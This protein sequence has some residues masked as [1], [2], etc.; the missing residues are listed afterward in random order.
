MWELAGAR[1]GCECVSW[2][3]WG[4]WSSFVWWLDEIVGEGVGSGAGAAHCSDCVGVR[5]FSGEGAGAAHIDATGVVVVAVSVFD[6]DSLG[7]IPA[8]N[9]SP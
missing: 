8:Q 7:A 3:G 4:G 5:E 1:S 9:S 2:W 6:G